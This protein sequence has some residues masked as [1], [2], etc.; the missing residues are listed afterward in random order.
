MG[1]RHGRRHQTAVV[2]D[3]RKQSSRNRTPVLERYLLVNRLGSERGASQR[4][5]ADC[6]VNDPAVVIRCTT[7]T[8][9]AYAIDQPRFRHYERRPTVFRHECASPL[10]HGPAAH[11][12]TSPR[13]Q[14][15]T[16]YRSTSRLALAPKSALEWR[17][18]KE[19]L[20]Q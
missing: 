1:E 20:R 5:S 19:V 7:S 13:F 3:R 4:D 2:Y 10:A 8:P 14:G 15:R 17:R 6:V 12:Y 16:R 18:L 9:A 11:T